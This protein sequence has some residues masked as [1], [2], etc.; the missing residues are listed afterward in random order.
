MAHSLFQRPPEE[1]TEGT[2]QQ[3]DR[4]ETPSLIK[5]EVHRNL[6]LEKKISQLQQFSEELLKPEEEDKML[7]DVNTLNASLDGDQDLAETVQSSVLRRDDLTQQITGGTEQRSGLWWACEEKEEM[8]VLQK[9]EEEFKE[10]KLSTN[11][12]GR[13][14][15]V[16][17]RW[18]LS[19]RS[20]YC[21]SF[22]SCLTINNL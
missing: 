9:S 15:D 19:L 20:A 2:V 5:G 1:D 17:L 18:S 14:A 4:E 6:L 7:G 10:G 11:V 8:W 13:D 3:L 21:V 22:D 16:Q 12:R